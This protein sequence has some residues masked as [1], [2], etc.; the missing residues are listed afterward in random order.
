MSAARDA[1]DIQN[2][3]TSFQELEKERLTHFRVQ[4]YYWNIHNKEN[5]I[6]KEFILLSLEQ[7]F[8]KHFSAYSLYSFLT[9]NMPNGKPTASSKTCCFNKKCKSNIVLLGQCLP[10]FTDYR[11]FIYMIFISSHTKNPSKKFL[12][13]NLIRWFVPF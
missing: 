13:A 11:H 7:A 1:R 8:L 9:D 5:K 6:V 3:C 2:V 4:N 10:S 12:C